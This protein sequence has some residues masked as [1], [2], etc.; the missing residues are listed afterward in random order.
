MND[1]LFFKKANICVLK[2]KRDGTIEKR[3]DR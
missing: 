3:Y 1:T 2:E